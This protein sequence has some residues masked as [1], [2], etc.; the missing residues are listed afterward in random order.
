[1]GR[2][3]VKPGNLSK[4]RRKIYFFKGK[5]MKIME[6]FSSKERLGR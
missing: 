4:D 1:L 2:K 6:I 3:I 5:K